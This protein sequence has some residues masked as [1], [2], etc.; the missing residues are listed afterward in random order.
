MK[1]GLLMLSLLLKEIPYFTSDEIVEGIP[2]QV[3]QDNTSP[4]AP[5]IARALRRHVEWRTQTALEFW[6]ELSAV[7]NS[8]S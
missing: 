4:Y 8:S 7:T 1:I 5:V 3:A 2:Q 6:R